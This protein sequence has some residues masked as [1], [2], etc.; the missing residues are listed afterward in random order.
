MAFNVQSKLFGLNSSVE[1]KKDNDFFPNF[2]YAINNCPLLDICVKWNAVT[3]P[4][5]ACCR[6]K[7][8]LADK[9]ALVFEELQLPQLQNGNFLHMYI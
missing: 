4:L 1:M 7:T 3:I 9:T 6:E 5:R 8:S 2:Y